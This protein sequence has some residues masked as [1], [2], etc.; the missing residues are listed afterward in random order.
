MKD[1]DLDLWGALLVDYPCNCSGCF[2]D[3]LRWIQAKREAK[4]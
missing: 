4:R 2:G 1:K 3:W